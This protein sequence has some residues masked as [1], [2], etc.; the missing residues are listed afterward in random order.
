MQ[1]LAALTLC[2]ASAL[3]QDPDALLLQA[4]QKIVANIRNLPKY[5]CV[6][7]LERS[8]FVRIPMSQEPR[9]CAEV[10]DLARAN[11]LKLAWTDRM[12][13]DVAVA[14]GNEIFSWAG[15]KQFQYTDTADIA[16]DGA[17]GTGDFG[18]FLADMFVANAASFHFI[19]KSTNGGEGNAVFSYVVPKERSHYRLKTGLS[20][21]IIGYHGIVW[22]DPQSA[23]LKR[24]T[25]VTDD[26]PALSQ[27]CEARDE[28]DYRRVTIGNNGFL[29]PKSVELTM[30][31]TKGDEAL[32]KTSYDSCREYLGQ[33][34]IHFDDYSPTSSAS[35]KTTEP[36][37]I[38]PGTRFDIQLTTALDSEHTAAGD[39]IEGTLLFATKVK[40][41]QGQVPIPKGALVEGRVIRM[42]RRLFPAEA[43]ILSVRFDSVEINGVPVPFLLHAVNDRS[44]IPAAF[45]D[46]RA[47]TLL[48]DPN[49]QR[50]GVGTYIYSSRHMVLKKFIS[51]WRSVQR[52]SPTTGETPSS[53][54]P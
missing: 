39:P 41:K 25:I 43:V 54:H 17:M 38:P 18:G 31:S 8:Y 13:L 2:A 27:I 24:L 21:E 44:E 10:L 5:T 50:P 7:T 35:A 1:R 49:E 47:P 19:G 15:A 11:S 6:Q 36:V 51:H 46:P 33:S 20:N 12:R 48:L 30:L 32:N 52:A 22:L 14:G 42:Q 4:R 45:P 34:T 26:P 28:M 29:L 23:D 40:Q 3:A 53:P 16:S 37:T 9:A